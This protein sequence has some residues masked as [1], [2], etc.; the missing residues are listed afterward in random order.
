MIVFVVV[1]ILAAIAIRYLGRTL[2]DISGE[3]KPIVHKIYLAKSIVVVMFGFF[4]IS[5]TMAYGV[6]VDPGSM[7]CF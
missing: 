4:Q 5:V 6:L 7:Q 3:F 1:T 2:E